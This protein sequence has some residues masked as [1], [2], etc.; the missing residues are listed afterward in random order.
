MT[1]DT[2]TPYV[3]CESYVSDTTLTN[4]PILPDDQ[5][6]PSTSQPEKDNGNEK[7]GNL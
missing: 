1:S 3:S 2:E 6:K 7:P 4:E 5:Q